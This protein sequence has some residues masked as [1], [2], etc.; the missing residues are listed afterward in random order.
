MLA[1]GTSWRVTGIALDGTF[2]KVGVEAYRD[3]LGRQIILLTIM[4]G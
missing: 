1:G 2:A 4:D 3:H